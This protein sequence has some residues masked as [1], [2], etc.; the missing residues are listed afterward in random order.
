[1]ILLEAGADPA[2]IVERYDPRYVVAEREV[3][4]REEAAPAELHPD[5]RLLLSTSGST[6]SP[7][8]VRLTARNVLANAES[9]AAYLGLTPAE[10]AIASLP[11]PYSYG[12]SV[13]TSHLRAGASV[14]FTPHSV[15]RPEFWDDARRLEATSFAGVPYSYAML[16][17]IG[18]RDMRLPALRTMT[19]AGGRLDP[20]IALRHAEQRRF[21]VMYGQTEATARIAYVP[22]ERLREKAGS[23]GIAIPGGAL[24]VGE[25]DEL[26]YSGPNVMMGYATQR[27]DLARGDELHGVLPTGDLGAVDADGFFSV[28]GRLKRIA[29]VFGQ[30]VNLDEVEAAVDGPAGAVAAEDAIDVYAERGADARTLAR[31][32]RVPPRAIR[33]HEVE[34]LPVKASGKVD[35]A[36]LADG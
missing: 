16:E 4:V 36:A 17:R 32:F 30:R 3:H 12:L 14:A 21:F 8:L 31:R 11:I 23:I 25:G 15:I 24:R 26:V 33:V 28:T 27:A 9:I 22:P 18:M 6:G 10:R 7:K 19:Q 5:L 2:Q 1:M 13:L 34:A 20:E 29:K 35:Y